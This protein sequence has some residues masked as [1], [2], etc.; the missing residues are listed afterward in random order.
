MKKGE[1]DVPLIDAF[2]LTEDFVLSGGRVL[3]R[4]MPQLCPPPSLHFCMGRGKL[5]W[6]V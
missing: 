5:I 2:W 3:G 1:F 6:T 4:I